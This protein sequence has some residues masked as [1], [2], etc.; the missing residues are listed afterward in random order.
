MIPGSKTYDNYI[1]PAQ[2]RNDFFRTGALGG[3][4][5]GIWAVGECEMLVD[6]SGAG[7]VTFSFGPPVDETWVVLNVLAGFITAAAATP[8]EFGDLGAALAN[9]VR[10]QL[11]NSTPAINN[12]AVLNTNADFMKLGTPTYGNVGAAALVIAATWDP[13]MPIILRGNDGERLNF[14]INDDLTLVAS[15]TFWAQARAYKYVG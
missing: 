8:I 3:E 4:G 1:I 6:G 2:V 7:G 5:E 9:G 15:T 14:V 13:D 11:A 10:F 12:L